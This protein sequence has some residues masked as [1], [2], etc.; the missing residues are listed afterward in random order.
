[1]ENDRYKPCWTENVE[2]KRS[3]DWL[4]ILGGRLAIL[5]LS[6]QAHQGPECTLR[7]VLILVSWK[8]ALDHKPVKSDRSS[9][10]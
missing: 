1:M 8:K 2:Y 3:I 4:K 7:D 10:H 9:G 5:S 6:E